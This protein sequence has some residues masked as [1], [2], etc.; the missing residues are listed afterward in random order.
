MFNLLKFSKPLLNSHALLFSVKTYQA[1]QLADGTL[2]A[3][4][5]DVPNLDA[6]LAAGVHVFGWIGD[7]DGADDLTVRKRIDLAGVSWDS[8]S[9]QGIGRKWHWLG[10]P[11]A[12]HVKRIGA[13]EDRRWEIEVSYGCS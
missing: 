12:V 8:R 11:L 7:G 13:A 9:R 4:L 2:A 6:P 5:G 3:G 1:I 10:S